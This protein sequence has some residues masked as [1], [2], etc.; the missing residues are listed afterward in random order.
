MGR[1]RSTICRH[2]KEPGL[3]D[4]LADR[5]GAHVEC[6]NVRRIQQQRER[7][8]SDPRRFKVPYVPG[9]LCKNCG[10]EPALEKSIIGYGEACLKARREASMDESRAKYRERH[11]SVAPKP[12]KPAVTPVRQ[13]VAAPKPA[14]APKL[15]RPAVTRSTKKPDPM[16]PRPWTMDE[17]LASF[18]ARKAKLAISGEERG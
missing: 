11:L 15:P 10:K 12:P 17:I 4:E 18:A 13:A 3:P 2:C 9:M 7:M 14:P 16:D 8:G 6:D 1:Q 5:R